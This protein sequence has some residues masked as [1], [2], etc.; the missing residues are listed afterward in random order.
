[1]EYQYKQKEEYT[2]MLYIPCQL[3]IPFNHN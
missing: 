2:N 3:D 1:M